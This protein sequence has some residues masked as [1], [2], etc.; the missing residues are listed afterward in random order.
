MYETEFVTVFD[1]RDAVKRKYS[2]AEINSDKTEDNKLIKT[3]LDGN[4]IARPESVNRHKTTIY[5]II[6]KIIHDSEIAADLVQKTF[7]KAFSSLA[8]LRPSSSWAKSLRP[9]WA[10]NRLS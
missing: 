2:R 4:Q 8:V 6:S 5:H 9:V 3:A 10:P 1:C 7:M